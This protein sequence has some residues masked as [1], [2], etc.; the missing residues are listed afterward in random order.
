MFYHTDFNVVDF[1]ISR[2]Y[3]M[4]IKWTVSSA[5][6]TIL[7]SNTKINTAFIP[8]IQTC[9]KF[10]RFLWFSFNECFS[11]FEIVLNESKNINRMKN[12]SRT[13]LFYYSVCVHV[14]LDIWVILCHLWIDNVETT[15][16]N[17]VF[18]F[19]IILPIRWTHYIA[20]ELPIYT[21][22]ESLTK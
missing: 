1:Q 22:F 18:F 5:Y 14:D 2:Q 16:S 3:N 12:W 10:N 17:F 13:L 19:L 21:V 15:I 4:W 9:C 7:F 20:M 11:W 8:N 6:F